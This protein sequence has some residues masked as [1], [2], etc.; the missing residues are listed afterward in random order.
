MFYRTKNFIKNFYYY[1]FRK[2]FY[3]NRWYNDDTKKYERITGKY[4]KTTAKDIVDNWYDYTAIYELIELKLYQMIKRLLKDGNHANWYINTL[5][6]CADN[7]SDEDKR[8]LYDVAFENDIKCN[9]ITNSHT[10]WYDDNNNQRISLEA[11]KKNNKL[12]LVIDTYETVKCDKPHSYRLM[13]SDEESKLIDEQFKLIDK[14]KNITDEKELLNIQKQID[15]INDKRKQLF[16]NNNITETHS[17]PVYEKTVLKCSKTLFSWDINI[18]SQELLDNLIGLPVFKDVDIIKQVLNSVQTVNITPEL[19]VK[20]SEDC[21]KLCCGQRNDI[22]SLLHF[23][24]MIKNLRT[25][26]D[27]IDNLVTNNIMK[28]AKY[29]AEHHKEW[30]D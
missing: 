25:M 17:K 11:D 5:G 1:C 4:S 29:F 30:W 19:Y 3:L 20:L 15:E 21:K 6:S 9:N 7:I 18:T 13:L 24:R 23:R 14:A 8:L 10:I 2:P 27:D 28:A 22:K 16:Y 12:N 26:D